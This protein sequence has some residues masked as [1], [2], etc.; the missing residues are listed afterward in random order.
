MTARYLINDRDGKFAPAF[1][2]AFR[3]ESIE[4]VRT[5]YRAPTASAIAERWVGS[6]RRE[7]LD[8][9]LLVDQAHVRRVVGVYVAHYIQA[10]EW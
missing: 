3:S 2:T 4:I 5:P 1:N 10:S 8:H 9:L 7:C 6:V